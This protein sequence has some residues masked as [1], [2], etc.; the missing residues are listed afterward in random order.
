MLPTMTTRSV[1]RPAAAS[2]GG[3]TGGRAGRSGGRTRGCSGDQGDGR[4][5]A[6]VGDQGRGQG[7]G[8]NQNG[9]VINDNVRGDVGRGCTYEFLA[10]NPKESNGKGGVIVYTCWIEKMESV[11]DMSRCRDSKRVKYTAGSFVGKALTWW[12]SQIYTRGREADLWNH[13]MVGVG[14]VAYTDR[15]HELARLVHHL[16]TPEGKRI[17]RYAYGPASQI[18]GMVAATEP[19]TIQKAVQ[20]AGTLTD[21]A[22]RNGSIK[23]TMRREEIVAPRNVNPI[24]ARNPVARACYEYGSIDHIKLACHRLNQAQRPGVNYQNH[25]MAINGVKV[26]GTK[27]IRQEVGHSCWEQRRL[28]RTRNI[29]TGTFTLN[30]HYATTLFDSGAD[31][32]FISTTF[33]PLL[34]IEPNDL[35]FSYEIEIASGQLVEIDKVIRA[36]RLEIEGH[37]FDINLIPFGM[38]IPLLEGNVLRVLG[39]KPEEKVRQL[40]SARTKEQKQ[41]EIVV[42][43]YFLEVFLN[44]LSGLPPVRENKFRIELV[45]GAMPVEKSLYRLTPSEL[46]ELSGK[47][48]E[49]QNKGYY[50]RFIKDFSKIAKPLTVLT[51]NSKTYNWG[52]E[53]ENAFQTLKDKLK[54]HEKNY[55]THNLELGTVVFALKIWRAQEGGVDEPAGLQKGLD[56]IIEF[57]NDG[58]LYY[59]DRIWCLTCLKVKAENQRLLGV[60]QQPEISLSFP[61]YVGWRLERFQLIGTLKFSTRDLRRRSRRLRIDLRLHVIKGVVHFGK[62][63]KLAPRFVEPFEI[64]EKVGPVA[65]RLDLSEELNGVHDT[66]HVSKLKMCLADPTLQVPFDEIQVDAKLNFRGGACGNLGTR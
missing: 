59:L 25:V 60:S 55:T 21:E 12:N 15:F 17:E 3:G 6:Q 45:P 23:K 43:I 26:V 65:Y 29:V 40:M 37:V 58:A 62:K 32:S 13:A 22:L 39:Q 38:R 35:G 51:Q 30:N 47:L 36:C 42:V 8:R 54:I 20:I 61:D 34:G 18:R 16:V 49:L 9:D 11:Q 14:H 28:A 50:R 44:D 10:C 33:I 63:G 19:K 46:E 7:N 56:E 41:K 66:F 52:K 64:I 48:K 1:G 57:R 4:I 5:D 2:R 27:G 24:N 31:Y 53:Q